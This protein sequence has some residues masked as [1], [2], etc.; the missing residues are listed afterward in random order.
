[1]KILTLISFVSLSVYALQLPQSMKAD[2]TQKVTN[3]HNQTL[4]YKGTF[5]FKAPAQS[6]WDYNHPSKKTVCVDKNK[7][8]IIEHELE[9][10]GIYA[11]KNHIKIQTL[12]QEAVKKGPQT[13]VT[14]YNNVEYKLKLRD[15]KLSSI[16]FVD[17]LGNHSK[18]TLDTVTYDTNLPPLGCDIPR[19]YDLIEN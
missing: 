4:S 8:I 15:K 13:Y 12:L 5:Y 3:E 10:A 1:M 19:S 18:I 2:F 6:R 16:E 17:E 7:I 14:A 11:N 9:Q